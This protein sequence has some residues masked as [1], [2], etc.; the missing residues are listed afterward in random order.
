MRRCGEAVCVVTSAWSGRLGTPREPAARAGWDNLP[1]ELH[2]EI[3]RL[4]PLRDATAAHA[5]SWEMRDEVDEVDER[6]GHSGRGGGP[7]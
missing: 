3:L 5:V 2:R 6:V 7:S 1:G 4:V